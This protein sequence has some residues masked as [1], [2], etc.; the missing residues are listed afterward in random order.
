MEVLTFLGYA[1]MVAALLLLALGV[2]YVAYGVL[3]LAFYVLPL[4]LGFVVVGCFR[5]NRVSSE[6]DS[7]GN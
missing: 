6:R 4:V 5:N 2:L 1:A 3:E 7:F